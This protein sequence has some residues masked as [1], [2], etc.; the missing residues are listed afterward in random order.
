MP[1]ARYARGMPRRLCTEPEL[2][3]AFALERFL[4]FKH[5]TICPTSATAFAEYQRWSAAHSEVPTGWID[6]IAERPLAQAVAQRT[7]IRHESPQA[8]L[9][10]GGRPTW[11]ASH[12]AITQAS[13]KRATG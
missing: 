2:E 4:L 8:I 9:L 1:A 13:L 3:A 12:G 10:R 6:V 5:S 7:G 11:N